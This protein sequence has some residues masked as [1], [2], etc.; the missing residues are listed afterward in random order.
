MKAFFMSLISLF[1]VTFLLLAIPTSGEEEIYKGTLRLHV[2]ADSDDTVDQEAKLYVRDAI[3]STF[4]A[5]FAALCDQTTAARYAKENLALIEQT[6]RETLVAHG[7]T[8]DVTADVTEEWFDTRNYG[9]FTLPA[10]CYTAL[11]ITLGEGKGQNFWCMLY[12]AL[13]TAPA[14]G[15]KIDLSE[16][17]GESTRV[18]IRGGYAVKFRTLEFLSAIFHH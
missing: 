7:L 10:G 16:A 6:A 17:Y 12:P 15:E 2:L 11:K 5:D 13:C 8:Y 9:D 18:L 14:M 3:L 1:M 4:G